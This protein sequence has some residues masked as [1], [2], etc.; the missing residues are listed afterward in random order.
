MLTWILAS[1][2]GT[3]VP[4]A[5]GAILGAVGSLVFIVRATGREDRF[6]WSRTD[7]RRE[8]LHAVR[9]VMSMFAVIAWSCLILAIIIGEAA[10]TALTGATALIAGAGLIYV[11]T[12]RGDS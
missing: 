12:W 1:A 6:R 10:F 9:S 3:Y 4:V 7:A 2:A 5:V 8:R 11:W